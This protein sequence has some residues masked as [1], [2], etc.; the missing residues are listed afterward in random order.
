MNKLKLMLCALALTLAPLAAYAAPVAG[1]VIS[2]TGKPQIKAAGTQA[3]KRLALN[4]FVYEG[5]TVKTG[6]GEKVGIAFVGGAELRINENSEFEME[7]GGGTKPTSVKTSLGQGWTRLLHGKSG[8]RVRTPVAV[9]AVRGTEADVDM[10]GRMTVKVY[11]GHVDV[12]NEQGSQSMTAGQMTQVGGAG[13]APDAPKAMEAADVG[14]WQNGLKP[15][16]LNKSQALLKQAAEKNR[17]LELE[18]EK[19]GQKKKVKIN[20]EKK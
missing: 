14:T 8:I 2:L 17:T 5:D 18:M 10:N 11:E 13:Q 19:D 9:C 6:P 3:L 4:R 12:S 7:S 20:L 16:D 1:V 15:A